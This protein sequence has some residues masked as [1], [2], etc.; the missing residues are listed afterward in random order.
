MRC[1][2][3]ALVAHGK[4]DRIWMLE[5][6]LTPLFRPQRIFDMHFLLGEVGALQSIIFA[7]PHSRVCKKDILG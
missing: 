2:L 1:E 4:D 5:N 6:A 3:S 7:S